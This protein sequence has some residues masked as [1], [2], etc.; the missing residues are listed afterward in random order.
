VLVA[1]SGGVLS[2]AAWMMTVLVVVEVRPFWSVATWSM[3]WVATWGLHALGRRRKVVLAPRA[4][5]SNSYGVVVVAGVS[6]R[7]G[8]RAG[9]TWQYAALVRGRKSCLLSFIII[10]QAG[11]TRGCGLRS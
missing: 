1:A 7:R 8:H 4:G 3:V 5:T 9:G 6:L 2:L 10:A 11:R